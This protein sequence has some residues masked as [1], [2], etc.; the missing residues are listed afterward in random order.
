MACVCVGWVAD[1]AGGSGRG[2]VVAIGASIPSQLRFVLAQLRGFPRFREFLIYNDC[3]TILNTEVLL[4]VSNV[5]LNST[6]H[7]PLIQFYA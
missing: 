6:S 2:R 3:T 7:C 4:H 1:G 5:M